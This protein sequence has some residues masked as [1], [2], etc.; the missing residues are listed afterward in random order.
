MDRND[1]FEGGAQTTSG[2]Q[3]DAAGASAQGIDELRSALAEH[4]PRIPS[5]Y[6]YDDRG[7]ALFEQI[8]ALPEYYPTRTERELLRREASAI[9]AAAGGEVGQ[10]VELGSGAASKTVPLLQAVLGAGRHPRYLAIDISV[11]ALARTGQLL[12]TEPGVEVELLCADYSRGLVLSRQQG[13]GSRLAIF[14]GGTIGNEDD[15]GAIR[16]F[17]GLRE[18]LQ[19]GDSLLVGASLVADPLAIEAAYNDAQGVTAAFNRNILTA[20]NRLVGARFDPH[21]FEHHAPYDR[22]NRRI[23]MWLRARRDLEVELGE[24]GGTLRLARGEGIR[25]EISRRF[26]RDELEHILSR[27]GFA[28]RGW[29]SSPDGRFGLAL[30]TCGSLH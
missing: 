2:I 30:G 18:Q 3:S 7:S 15:A 29:F 8:M 21:T 6:F 17:S 22:V 13:Q 27:S 25:T 10:I 16:L 11:H 14:L 4:P 19:E 24:L 12:A 9:L 20:V 23:E 28:P 1:G 26:T 5:K